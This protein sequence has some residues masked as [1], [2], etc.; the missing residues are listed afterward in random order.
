MSELRKASRQLDWLTQ[1]R[2]SLEPSSAIGWHIVVCDDEVRS[3]KSP[4]SQPIPEGEVVDIYSDDETVDENADGR[5]SRASRGRE[6][7]R[8]EG[9]G[10][11]GGIREF[12]RGRS[13]SVGGKLRKRGMSVGRGE[14]EPMPGTAL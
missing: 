12:L 6:R 7:G 11:G 1:L 9:A 10:K 8:D 3:Y 5:D 14:E 13:K 4:P 2:D